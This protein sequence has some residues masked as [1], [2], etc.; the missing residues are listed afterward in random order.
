MWRTHNQVKHRVRWVETAL[1]RAWKLLNAR[2]G[3]DLAAAD[4]A[5]RRW[6][7]LLRILQAGGSNPNGTTADS[8]HAPSGRHGFPLIFF[9][10]DHPRCNRNNYLK[11]MSVPVLTTCASV[12]CTHALPFPNYRTVRDSRSRPSSWDAAF[13]RQASSQ[14]WSD[15]TRQVVW[16]GSLTGEGSLSNPSPRIRLGLFA[17]AH[18]DH[19]LLDI[20]IRGVPGGRNFSTEL[21]EQLLMK[22]GI[23]MGNFSN[24]RA[25]LDA[26]GNSW[27]SRFGSLLCTN[28]VVLKVEPK[29]VD[30]FNKY[31]EPWTH[32]I[33]VRSDLSDLME[34]VEWVLSPANEPR[35]LQIVKSAN[36]WCRTHMTYQGV[37]LDMLDV[38][39][40][41]V[42]L[43]DRDDARW[44]D[45]WAVTRARMWDPS[46]GWKM[47][48][49]EDFLD[50]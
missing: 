48:R 37:A 25:I 16:R 22:P 21:L 38:L 31:L 28:S 15:K 4:A 26:D 9:H 49:L 13:K 36:G 10:G 18:R 6:P 20:G 1:D 46:S 12:Q 29:Y 2:A 14:P 30:Y 23:P 32:Y 41:Y 3:A 47:R 39:N 7:L 43:L 35:V 8:D 5:R 33:P 40:A 24:Y 17:A 34:T 42:A 11:N 50:R 27:S 19:P 45:A 44:T